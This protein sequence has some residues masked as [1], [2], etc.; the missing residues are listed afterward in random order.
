MRITHAPVAAAIAF[1]AAC[2][3]Q[4]Y[5]AFQA[6]APQGA[7]VKVLDGATLI[8]GNGGE[9]LANARL[10][11][12]DGRVRYAGPAAAMPVPASAART[13]LA[14][15]YIMPGIINLH[16]HLGSVKGLVQDPANYTP[17]NLSAQLKT[18]ASYGV[19]SV[20]SMGSDQP[21]ILE[22][23]EKQR[24]TGRPDTTRIFTAY[25][26]FTGKDGYPTKAPGMAGV[27]FEVSK[28]EEVA[29]A[30]EELAAKKVDV[31]KMWVDDHLGKER[32]IPL[33]L[34]KA[35]IENAHKHG[36]KAVAHVF[37]LADAKKLVEYGLDGLVHSIRDKPVDDELINLMKNRGA[38][39]AAATFTREA[40]TFV[41]A[42]PSPMLDDPFFT[43][44]VNPE[45][46]TTL[47]S[48]EYQ[49]K[50]AASP[51]T[52]VFPGF[53]KT[54]Q[55]NLKKLVEAGVKHGFGTDTG[56]PAR[57]SGYFEHWEM[58]LMAEAGLTPQQII[59]SFSKNAA[60][61]LG[62][63]K[64][65]GTIEAG[66]WAD[67]I[68]LDANPLADIKNSRTINAVYIGGNKVQ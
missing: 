31:V 68:V 28:P 61:F 58:E 16:G 21:L 27:P 60:E 46:L 41:Y 37:Y 26:G 18:Y 8:D 13:D 36:I 2:S 63:T 1:L 10:V 34:C 30:V 25:R 49:A 6:L 52:K 12:V 32:K 24:A 67:L 47:K 64:D 66:H 7:E 11:I 44:S 29:A 53:L 45:V 15:K 23:R 17:E 62:A 39:Q 22:F 14:G 59:Q 3:S 40:S 55:E 38:W 57:F 9:P 20:I 35:I 56:P 5:S 51:D 50:A 54:A 42:K 65:L 19:T 33:D 48:P 4:D 43:R